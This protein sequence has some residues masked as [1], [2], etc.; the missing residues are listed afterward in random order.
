MK[1]AEALICASDICSGCAPKSSKDFGPLSFQES[2]NARLWTPRD[3]RPIT[4]RMT[5]FVAIIIRITGPA[6]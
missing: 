2:G 1:C 3:A 4:R 6:L 5:Q